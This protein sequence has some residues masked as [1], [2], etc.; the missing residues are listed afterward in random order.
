MSLAEYP[1]PE[2]RC[3]TWRALVEQRRRGRVVERSEYEFGKVE[4]VQ[5]GRVAVARG[6]DDRDGV[7]PEPTHDEREGLGRRCVQPVRVVDHD[8]DRCFGSADGEQLERGQGDEVG[9]R[10]GRLAHAER[11]EQRL[12]LPAGQDT[13]PVEDRTEELMEPGERQSGLRLDA[14]GRED[15]EAVGRRSRGE[16]RQQG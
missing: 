3:Q 9:I 8:E 14:R 12:A 2:A 6:H 16:R 15:L 5:G 11:G 13:R 7:F 1:G 4:C 10:S